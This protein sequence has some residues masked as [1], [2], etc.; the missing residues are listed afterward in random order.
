MKYDSVVIG[1]GPTGANAALGSGKSETFHA[2][3]R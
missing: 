2:V 3:N 1:G